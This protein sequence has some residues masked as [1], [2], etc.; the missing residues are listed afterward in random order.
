M[1]DHPQTE[2]LYAYLD[3]E[4]EP[5]I[6]A[7]LD[8]HFSHCHQC[9]GRLEQARELFGRIGSVPEVPMG[10]NLAPAVVAELV[11]RRELPVTLPWWLALQGVAAVAAMSAWLML[12]PIQWPAISP[13]FEPFDLLVWWTRWALPRLSDLQRAVAAMPDYAAELLAA[14]QAPDIPGLGSSLPW[15][16]ILAILGAVWLLANGWLLGTDSWRRLPWRGAGLRKESH[17]G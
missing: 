2:Q 12:K 1:S 17:H 14:V 8:R 6:M 7:G 13:L 3:A 9:Q 15:L 4:L 5:S 16:P 11:E 10:R